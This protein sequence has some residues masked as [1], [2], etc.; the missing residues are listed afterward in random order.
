M[1]VLYFSFSIVLLLTAGLRAAESTEQRIKKAA[2]EIYGPIAVEYKIPGL[3]VGVAIEGNTFFYTHGLA[4]RDHG[5]PATADTIFELGS[6][7]KLFNVALSALAEQRGLLSLGDPVESVFPQLHGSRFGG[8]PL[9]DLAAHATGSLPLQVPEEI[10]DEAELMEYLAKWSPS[11][12]PKQSRSYSNVSIGVLGLAAGRA[13]GSTFQDAVEKEILSPLG[14][15]NT[16][17]SVPK[18]REEYYAIGYTRDEGL[19][20]RV[21]PGMLAIEAYGIKSTARDMTRFLQAHLGE[22][23]LSQEL[24]RSLSRTRQADFTT[25]YYSQAMI[26][27]GYPWPVDH[28]HLR[29]GNAAEFILE[30]QAM[31]PRDRIELGG[32]TYLNKTGSTNGFGAYVALLPSKRI[33]VVALANRPYPNPIRAE[34]AARLIEQLVE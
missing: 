12:E 25:R 24:S 16:F 31:S 15:E 2:A 4:D 17:V 8:I 11:A 28:A 32:D 18:R 26:W 3:V 7:S 13:F 6:V 10:G 9:N 27:E 21:K 34:A 29:A 22:I 5:I 19:P 14:L 1:R 20:I 30:R 33:G 23:P